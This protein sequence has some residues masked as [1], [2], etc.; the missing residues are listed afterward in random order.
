MLCYLGFWIDKVIRKLSNLL[1]FIPPST[2]ISRCLV[3]YS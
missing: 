3:V 1:S 2:C